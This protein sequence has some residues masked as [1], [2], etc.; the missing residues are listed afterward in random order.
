MDDVSFGGNPALSATP[1]GALELI[2][3]APK[4]ERIDIQYAKQAKKI[5]VKKLKQVMWRNIAP[6]H[7]SECYFEVWNSLF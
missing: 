6:E 1:I 5:D 4:I 2:D 7:D 3:A